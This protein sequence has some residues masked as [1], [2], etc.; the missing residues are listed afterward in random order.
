MK[1]VF[2]G[3]SVTEGCFELFPAGEGYDTVR[4][5]AHGY[6]SLLSERLTREFPDLSL[7]IINA[8]ISGNNTE[9][10]LARMNRDLI[11]RKPDAAVIAFGLNDVW[12]RNPK[13]YAGNL[14]RMFSAL[15]DCGAR[16]V[17]L[18]P[19]MM[20]TYV[21]DEIDLPCLL[22]TAKA[23]AEIQNGGVL[24]EYLLAG[25]ET[26]KRYGAI[27]CDVYG[28][29][30]RLASYGVD[31]TALLCNHINHPTREMHRLFADLLYPILSVF[32][33]KNL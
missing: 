6:V 22:E 16:A 9:D 33:S 32:I 1:I 28:E 19:N 4:D 11:A 2:F 8:G 29:W 27:V 21:S 3:D 13:R 25:T 12:Y 26:A 7:N 23:T 20:N 30:K 17:Y 24:D 18:T 15:R 5:P 10:G 14:A 31:T